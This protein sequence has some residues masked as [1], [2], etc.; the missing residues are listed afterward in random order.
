MSSRLGFSDGATAHGRPQHIAEH[1]QIS[2]RWT[3]CAALDTAVSSARCQDTGDGLIIAL[4]VHWTIAH[5]EDCHCGSTALVPQ[6]GLRTIKITHHG[7]DSLQLAVER[8]T[9]WR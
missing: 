1:A 4:G 6:D 2:C 9:T 5:N 7:G 8:V 3:A